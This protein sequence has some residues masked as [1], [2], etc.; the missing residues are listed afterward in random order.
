MNEI[1]A[2]KTG[3]SK[4]EAYLKIHYDVDV[5]YGKKEDNAYYSSC[6][7][8]TINNSQNFKCRLHT[9]LHEAGHVIIRN[10]GKESFKK[11]ARK[12]KFE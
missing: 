12:Q 6:N 5:I 4:I 7:Q 8:V 10:D 11:Q 3:I 2:I 9:L 1:F